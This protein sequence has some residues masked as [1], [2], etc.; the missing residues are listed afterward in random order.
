MVSVVL[1]NLTPLLIAPL[2]NTF[3]RI[4]DEG[5]RRRVTEL[6][7]KAGIAVKDVFEMDASI[8]TKKHNAYFT[9]LGNTKRVVLYDTLIRDSS[10][11]EVASVLAH[12][13]G[14]WQRKHIWKGIALAGVGSAVLLFLLSKLLLVGANWSAFRFDSP[15]DVASLPLIML[16]LTLANFVGSPVQSSISRHFERQADWTALVLTDNPGTFI[17]SEKKLAL[18]NLA[19]VDPP[20]FL[21][22]FFY[23][24]PSPLRRIRMAEEY[25]RMRGRTTGG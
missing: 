15:V 20:P 9:G 11:D 16:F 6:A 18:R 5:L 3:T 7:G 2:F 17:E 13:I 24:H 10:I 21:E 4:E 8:R 23:S 22:W 12:E 1:V 25:R 19:D 14:H